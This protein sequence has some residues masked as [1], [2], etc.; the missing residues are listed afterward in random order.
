MK[1]LCIEARSGGEPN[2]TIPLRRPLE[3]TWTAHAD[4]ASELAIAKP[5]IAQLNELQVAGTNLCPAFRLAIA[6]PAIARLNELPVASMNLC[7]ALAWRTTQHC[8]THAPAPASSHQIK[9][10]LTP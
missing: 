7:H 10:T 5:A 9:D 3:T 1:A 2:R 6:K 8:L 4:P